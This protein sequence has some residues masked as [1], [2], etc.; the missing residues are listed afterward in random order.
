MAVG[1]GV[2]TL[3]AAVFA[4]SQWPRGLITVP[5]F[6]RFAGWLL[7]GGG[8]VAALV[9]DRIVHAMSRES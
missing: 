7:I 8:C 4:V 2:V 5:W 9:V 6:G 1:A 3:L